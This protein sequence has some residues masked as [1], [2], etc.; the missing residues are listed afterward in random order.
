MVLLMFKEIKKL[1]NFP[2][3]FL[4]ND[5]NLN[6][7]FIPNPQN[8]EARTVVISYSFGNVVV[9]KISLVFGETTF[10]SRIDDEVRQSSLCTNLITNREFVPCIFFEIIPC[11]FFCKVVGSHKPYENP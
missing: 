1:G 5:K 10:V 7:K 3:L 6:L 4:F 9:D 2:K 11:I 8:Y